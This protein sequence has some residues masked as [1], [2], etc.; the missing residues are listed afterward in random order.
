MSGQTGRKIKTRLVCSDG[1]QIF[2]GYIHIIS[3][4]PE[5]K[6]ENDGGVIVNWSSLYNIMQRYG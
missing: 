1:L 3:S 5:S 4:S 2:F 6:Y